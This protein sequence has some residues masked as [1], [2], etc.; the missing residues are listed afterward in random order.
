M[1]KYEES[2]LFKILMARGKFTVFRVAVLH[3]LV[4]KNWYFCETSY[5]ENVGSLFLR[6]IGAYLPDYRGPTQKM[7]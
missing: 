7:K 3:S 2:F 5:P 4:D 1:E 6:Y